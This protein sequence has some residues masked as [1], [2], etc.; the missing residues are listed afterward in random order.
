MRLSIIIPCYNDATALRACLQRLQGMSDVE[1]IVADASPGS[2]CREIATALGATIVTFA[3]P[4]RGPQMN[5]GAA[6]ATGEVL[7]FNH[8]DTQL[9]ATHLAAVRACM[10]EENP[11]VL[12]GAFYKCPE[13]HY[14][15][16]TWG[17]ES[18]R[19]WVRD[20]GPIYGDQTIFFRRSHFHAL[21]GFP[22]I[23]IM[24]DVAMSQRLRN[25]GGLRLLDPAVVTSLRKFQQHGYVKTR[26]SNLLL[27]WL[28]Q[29]GVPPEAI[30]R[31]YYRS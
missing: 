9:T 11:P 14:P 26:L 20:W 1:C 29:L 10:A 6:V 2:E 13:H 23:P 25:A 30:Y 24:E 3:Q 28:Y 16:V 31:W 7:I 17:N 4:G 21:G 27:L 19:A 5:G 18:I 12:A 15:L 8:C 22:A